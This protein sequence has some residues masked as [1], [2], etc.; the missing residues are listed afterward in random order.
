LRA[1]LLPVGEDLYAVE[2]AVAREVV[3]VHLLASLPMA[4]A[5]VI[6]VFNLRGE[7]VPVFDTAMLLGVGTLPPP[8]YVA[9]VETSLGPAGLAM[10][11]VGESV[12]LD[13]PI[14]LAEAPGTTASYSL[15]DRMVVLVDVEVLLAS[16]AEA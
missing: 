10:T 9:I 15:G 14:G 1:L 11:A 5:S 3:A 6:G 12:E 8:A 16:R 2:M 7:I 4:P 13:E